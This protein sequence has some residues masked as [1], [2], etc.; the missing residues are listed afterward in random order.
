MRSGQGKGF[1]LQS[2]PKLRARYA[3]GPHARLFIAV[4]LP[5][6]SFSAHFCSQFHGYSWKQRDAAGACPCH[7]SR[8]SCPGEVE[9][10]IS[11]WVFPT[12][13]HL[14]LV[15]SGF[16]LTQELL[17]AASLG[18]LFLNSQ[19]EQNIGRGITIRL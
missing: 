14:E 11:R 6:T 5:S 9:H 10:L 7:S 4:F 16:S 15:A 2:Q 3:S 8:G 13:Q 12:R 1:C 17:S 19:K 18:K